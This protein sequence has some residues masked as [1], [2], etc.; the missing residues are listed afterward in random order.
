M[1]YIYHNGYAVTPMQYNH[2]AFFFLCF[3]SLSPFGASLI[4]PRTLSNPE[5]SSEFVTVVGSP[6]AVGRAPRFCF[7]PN[8]ESNS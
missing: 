8:A 5:T 1:K 7:F 6:R 4:A 2:L 3:L